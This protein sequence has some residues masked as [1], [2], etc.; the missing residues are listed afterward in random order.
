LKK[1][2]LMGDSILYYMVKPN[3]DIIVYLLIYIFQAYKK[4]WMMN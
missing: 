2:S 3:Y 1:S 4:V